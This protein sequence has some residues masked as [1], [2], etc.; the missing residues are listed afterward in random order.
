MS[1][2]VIITRDRVYCDNHIAMCHQAY[3][4]ATGITKCI[5]DPAAYGKR[6]LNCGYYY[7]GHHRGEFTYTLRKSSP[8]SMP[9]DW[10]MAMDL[11]DQR[12]TVDIYQDW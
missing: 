4:D 2:H 12:E 5:D 10:Q 8:L 6:L 3:D 1:N 9:T 7:A 11:A